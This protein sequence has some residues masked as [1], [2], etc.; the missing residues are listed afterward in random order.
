MNEKCKFISVRC[1]TGSGRSIRCRTLAESS[2][3]LEAAICGDRG[4]LIFNVLHGWLRNDAKVTGDYDLCDLAQMYIPE[5]S[6]RNWIALENVSQAIFAAKQEGVIFI[7]A[8]SPFA[9]VPVIK[10]TPVS[11]PVLFESKESLMSMPTYP[12]PPAPRNSPCSSVFGP[13]LAL[14]DRLL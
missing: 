1:N 9:L 8:E 10:P 7:D 13:V 2:P 4:Y 5:A 6:R 12:P 14:R 3:E 11:K